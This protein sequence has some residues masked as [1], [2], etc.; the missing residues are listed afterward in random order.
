MVKD[1]T[2]SL[3]GLVRGIYR[4]VLGRSPENGEEQGWV[5][6]L[7]GGQSVE[8]LLPA[9]LGTAEF[10]QRAAALIASG[11]PDER[12]IRALYT[13]LMQRPATTDE[14][15]AWLAALPE[16]G[17]D[18]VAAGLVRSNE[19]RTLEIQGFYQEVYGQ[20]ADAADAALWAASPLHLLAIRDALA[21]QASPV[22]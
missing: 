14:V 20:K 21:A 18:G 8:Q 16:L 7:L 13:V 19:F 9:F 3:T 2:E 10:G 11:T 17:R 12:Y 6:A 22:V 4:T 1:F 15:S 5:G